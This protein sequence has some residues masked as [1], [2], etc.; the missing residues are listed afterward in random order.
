[1]ATATTARQSVA[2]ARE[3]SNARATR[4]NRTVQRRSSHRHDFG[5]VRASS[6]HFFADRRGGAARRRV[7]LAISGNAAKSV[8]RA[9]RWLTVSPATPPEH[10]WSRG[11][12]R[13]VRRSGGRSRSPSGPMSASS[14]RGVLRRGPPAGGRHRLFPPQAP[15]RPLLGD[16]RA[17]VDLAARGSTLFA[18]RRFTRPPGAR[19]TTRATIAAFRAR[20]WSA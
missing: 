6:S 5:A 2:R 13:A 4:T 18:F 16:R 3:N 14:E 15:S 1:M 9:R 7:G 17:R 12:P 11:R 10:S 20:G 8:P 19:T